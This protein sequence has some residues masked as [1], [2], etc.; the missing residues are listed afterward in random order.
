MT[1][2]PLRRLTTVAAGLVC[3]TMASCKSTKKSGYDKVVDYTTPDTGLSQE[4]YPFDEKGNYLVDVVSGK[5]KGGKNKK[6]AA[7]EPEPTFDTPPEPTVASTQSP[8]YETPPSSNPYAPVYSSGN[9]SGSTASNVYKPEI[10]TYQPPSSSS[11]SKPKSTA[12]TKSKP[13]PKTVAKAK[14]KPKPKPAPKASA[15]SYTV[16]KGD[17]LYS[18]ANR[19]GTSVAAI[20]KASGLS[21]DTLRDGR[22]I[23]IPRK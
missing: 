12:S 3:L 15:T 10:K 1:A 4:E 18:L 8:N 6:I 2:F 14:V 13:T 11:S 7:P 9:S 19:Y 17:T 5:K 16:K 20:K 22:T 23:R 21:S